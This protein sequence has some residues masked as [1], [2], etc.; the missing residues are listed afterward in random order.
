MAGLYGL[1]SQWHTAPGSFSLNA[2]MTALAGTGVEPTEDQSNAE[3]KGDG[4]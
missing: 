3:K 4:T 2:A 1:M